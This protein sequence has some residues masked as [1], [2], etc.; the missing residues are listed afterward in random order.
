MKI[1]FTL[2]AWAAFGIFVVGPVIGSV[3]GSNEPTVQELAEREEDKRKGFHCLSSWDGSHRKL[4]TVLKKN[5]KDPSSYEHI[6]TRVTPVNTDGLH[7]AVV[8]YRA[9]NGFGGFA[10]GTIL[11]TYSNKNCNII[12]AERV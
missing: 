4:T 7:D 11:A 3:T 2:V 12:S 10:I 9:K 1:L 8:T 5:L 6:S